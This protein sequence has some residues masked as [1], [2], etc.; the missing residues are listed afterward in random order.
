MFI[1]TAWGP[2]ATGSVDMLPWLCVTQ[3]MRQS[4]SRSHS[5]LFYFNNIAGAAIHDDV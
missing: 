3:V 4:P 2:I 5:T 1:F